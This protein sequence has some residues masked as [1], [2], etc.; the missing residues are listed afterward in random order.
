MNKGDPVENEGCDL[1]GFGKIAKAIPK[2]VYERTAATLLTTFEQLT[3]PITESTGGLGRY[4][5]Q[6]FD[7]MVEAEKAIATY[8]VEKA[9]RRAQIKCERS[10]RT[11]QPPPHPKSFV[12]AIEEAS[13][14]TDPLLHEMWANLLASQ[15]ADDICHPH[16]VQALP[17]FSAA[18]ARLLV[19]LLPKSE[20]GAYD[21]YL[22]IESD[23]FTHWVRREGEELHAWSISCDLLCQFRFAD[24]LGLKKDLP[25]VTILHRTAIGG[26]FLCAV[27]PP[28]N[29][30]PPSAT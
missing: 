10:G 11:L 4:L 12:R 1:A 6:K 29:S 9:I 20:L 2:E 8:T 25:R 24:V 15:L 16:F 5:R 27:S 18:E 14:E 17:H 21:G 13:I 7:N 22:S 28:E 30:G 3:A 19:S 23:C 26:A